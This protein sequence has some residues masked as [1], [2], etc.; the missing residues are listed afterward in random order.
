LVSRVPHS[1]EI[2]IHPGI[3]YRIAAVIFP[4]QFE[5]DNFICCFFEES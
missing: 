4:A 3:P 5:I 1:D 2:D